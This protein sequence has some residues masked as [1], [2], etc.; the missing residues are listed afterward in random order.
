MTSLKEKS[1]MDTSARKDCRLSLAHVQ[2]PVSI[3]T[4]QRKFAKGNIE[5]K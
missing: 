1:E 2:S 3:E 4:K 5:K